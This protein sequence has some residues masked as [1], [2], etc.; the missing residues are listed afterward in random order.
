MFCSVSRPGRGAGQG[1]QLGGEGWEHCSFVCG[2]TS[3][4]NHRSEQPDQVLATQASAQ[5]HVCQC[6]ALAQLMRRPCFRTTD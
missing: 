4:T 6:V 1:E 5:H 3:P 2:A